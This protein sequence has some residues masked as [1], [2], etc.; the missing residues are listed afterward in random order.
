MWFS[1]ER[2]PNIILKKVPQQKNDYD[3][4]LYML[5]SIEHLAA[6]EELPSFETV[7]GLIAHFSG[8]TLPEQKAIDEKRANY[9]KGLI[10]LAE[11]QSQPDDPIV[12]SDWDG[13]ELRPSKRQRGRP[14]GAEELS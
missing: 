12:H 3:C 11:A 9:Y 1:T 5:S 7:D 2:M 8:A 6:A 14:D 13:E 10:K 4:G